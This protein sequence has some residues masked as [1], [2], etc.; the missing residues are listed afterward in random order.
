MRWPFFLF[1]YF[2]IS[3]SGS[4]SQKNNSN[5]LEKVYCAADFDSVIL[6][7]ANEFQ[8]KEID[9]EKSVS[10]ELAEILNSADS[11]CLKQSKAFE[12][13]LSTILLKLYI[14]H[15]RCCGMGYDLHGMKR[16]NAQVLIHEF[17]RIAGFS[18]QR[19]EFIN[20]YN[21]VDFVSKRGY[22][23]SNKILIMYLNDVRM[24]SDSLKLVFSNQ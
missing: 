10:A 8:P 24:V 19:I 1:C 6:L 4:N 3:C 9:L 23:A 2:F 16:G 18:N 21:I 12:L 5:E 11:N 22:L 20:S 7:Y 15:L 17:E 14:Y 13:A